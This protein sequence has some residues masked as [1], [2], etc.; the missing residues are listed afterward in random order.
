MKSIGEFF[1]NIQN[2]HAQEV[3]LR[4][5]IQQVL[6]KIADVDVGV[7]DVSLKSGTVT[8]KRISPTAKSFIFLK[9]QAILREIAIQVPG[10]RI[11]DLKLF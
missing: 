7:S 11:T 1:S 10:K 8:I 3:F 6:K 4:T 2:R 9:K 5:I